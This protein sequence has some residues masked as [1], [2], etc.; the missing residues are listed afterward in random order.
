VKPCDAESA[1]KL[2]EHSYRELA[3]NAFFFTGL[4]KISAR[5]RAE[6]HETAE[7]HIWSFSASRRVPQLLGGDGLSY[8]LL[9]ITS[10]RGRLDETWMVATSESTRIPESHKTTTMGLKLCHIIQ[11]HP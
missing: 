4:E 5:I 7:R 8:R 1:N 11:H 2:L 10:A 3:Q 6:R 9:E